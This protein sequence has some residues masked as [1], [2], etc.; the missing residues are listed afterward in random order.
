MQHPHVCSGENHVSSQVTLDHTTLELPLTTT[1]GEK[2][3]EKSP[4]PMSIESVGSVSFHDEQPLDPSFRHCS[5]KAKSGDFR[6][7]KN[8]Q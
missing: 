1:H 6:K 7:A 5:E 8:G 3:G 4:V 2:N